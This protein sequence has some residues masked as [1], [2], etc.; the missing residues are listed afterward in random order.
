CVEPH[1]I[2]ALDDAAGRAA[3]ASDPEDATSWR[4]NDD[5]WSLSI[6]DTKITFDEGQME[7]IARRGGREL[8]R[9]KHRRVAGG[10]FGIDPSPSGSL[11]ALFYSRGDTTIFDAKNG[12]VAATAGPSVVVAP[13][14]SY[15]IDTP[16]IGFGLDH[17]NGNE[18]TKIVFGAT[19]RTKTIA[20]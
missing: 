1:A 17:F 3:L 16:Q 12:R 7:I 8:W 13:D 5:P 19:P 10:T 11:V 4:R 14:D 18:V 9:A 6:A 20:K 2:V 15:A